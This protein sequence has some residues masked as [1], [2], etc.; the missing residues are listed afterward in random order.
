ML[1]ADEATAAQRL[2]ARMAALIPTGPTTADT[3]RTTL[4]RWHQQK[5]TLQDFLSLTPDDV[6][7]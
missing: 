5:T 2:A 6:H 4:A 3:L 7:L 1:A